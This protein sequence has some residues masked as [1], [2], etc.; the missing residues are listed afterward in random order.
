M[1][2]AC[3][4]DDDIAG[5]VEAESVSEG[6]DYVDD[7][8]S[9]GPRPLPRTRSTRS[10]KTVNYVRENEDAFFSGLAGYTDLQRTRKGGDK[11]PFAAGKKVI[12]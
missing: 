7:K 6:S 10:K 5:L 9:G 2:P 1:E 4:S 12:Y 11:R 3:D 8:E